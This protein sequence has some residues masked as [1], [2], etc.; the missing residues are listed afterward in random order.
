[1]GGHPYL[2]RLAMYEARRRGTPV[3]VLL[4][5]GDLDHGIF[6]PHLQEHLSR[7]QQES[8]LLEA[9]RRVLTN[10]TT[11]LS[12]ETYHRLKSAGLILEEAAGYR[13]RYRL[14]AEYLRTRA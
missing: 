10:P 2:V 3:A 7:L 8:P 12:L 4:N 13:P 9:V 11:H 5:M 14:Y 6:G 1:V